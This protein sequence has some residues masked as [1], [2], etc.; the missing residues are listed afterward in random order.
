MTKRMRGKNKN[1]LVIKYF[2]CSF[3]DVMNLK[4][5]LH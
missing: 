5:D 2:K 3:N 4:V 1:Y